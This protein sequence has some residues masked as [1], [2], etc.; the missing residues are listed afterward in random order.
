[1]LLAH[2]IAKSHRTASDRFFAD[3][4]GALP[5]QPTQSN[6][7]AEDSY[8]THTRADPED[9][10]GSSANPPWGAGTD[11]DSEDEDSRFPAPSVRVRV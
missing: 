4:G 5:I 1:M 9:S 7:R 6:A 2:S 10:G 11:Y 8:S 3:V